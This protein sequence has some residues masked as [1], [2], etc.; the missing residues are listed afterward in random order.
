MTYSSTKCLAS[1]GRLIANGT[2]EK[3]I[4][5]TSHHNGERWGGIMTKGKT[6]SDYEDTIEYCRIED[7]DYKGLWVFNYVLNYPAMNNCIITNGTYPSSGISSNGIQKIAIEGIRNVVMENANASL[8]AYSDGKYWNLVNNS[9]N[10]PKYSSLIEC[11]FF[12]N[13]F[14]MM[15]YNLKDSKYYGHEYW[16]RINA[17]GPEV[18]RATCPSYLGTA[19]EDIVRPHVYELG[20]APNDTWGTIDLSNMR[21]EPVREAHGIVWKVLVNGKD[22]QDEYEDL[23]PLGVGRHKFEVYFNRPMNKAV[24]PKL[25]FGVRD[26]W[27][28]N[29]VDEDAS[30]NADGTIYTAY[31]TITGKMSSDGINRIYVRGA[32][33]DEFF[34]CP[35]EKSRFNINVQVAGSMATGFAAEASV[36][37]VNLTWDNSQ[38]DIEDAMGYNVYRF[39]NEQKRTVFGHYENGRWI[40]THEVVDTIRINENILDVDTDNYIDSDVVPNRTYYYFYKVL[41]TDLREYDVSNIVAATP[42]TATMGDANGSGEVDV[43]DVV[44]TVNY[45]VGM[46]PAPFIFDAAD[47]NADKNIDVLDVI[48]IVQKVL[49]P[50]SASAASLQEYQVVYTV[51]NGILYVESPIDLAGVQVQMNLDGRCKK[52]EVRTSDELKEFEQ[53]SAWLTDDDYLLLAYSMS[54]KT[55]SAGKHA[56]LYIGDSDISQLRISDVNG[57]NVTVVAGDGTTIIDAMG[58]RV[59]RQEGIY[60]LYGRKLSTINSKLSTFKKGVYIING[61]KVVK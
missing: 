42:M 49:N 57:H 27:T 36:G 47:M 32:E 5:F 39:C 26:P 41:S 28:Q 17:T 15:D 37:R 60:D 33:D 11:N 19:R 24:E 58:S 18:D 12:N 38:N 51:E 10:L 7:C 43:A 3:P 40:D 8:E 23:A 34:P 21:K 2:I 59:Q 14:I 50:N 20:N 48:G 53:A 55:L 61:K 46:K 4:V 9:A 13:S 30:W 1:S 45:A 31:K 29:G 56:L 25:S 52:E 54:G 22:A 6:N 44:T 35:Y 16:L